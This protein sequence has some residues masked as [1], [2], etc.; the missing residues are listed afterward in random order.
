MGINT[1]LVTA[2]NQRELLKAEIEARRAS[3]ID[4]SGHESSKVFA[5]K[6]PQIDMSMAEWVK[7]RNVELA[8][9]QEEVDGY[10]SLDEELDK[11]DGMVKQGNKINRPP[12]SMGKR[13]RGAVAKFLDSDE[14]AKFAGSPSAE[15]QF[16]TE[17]SFKELFA[18]QR[19]TLFETFDAAVDGAV[20]VDVARTGEYVTVPRTEVTLLDVIPQL[21]TTQGQI[22]YDEQTLNESAVGVIAQGG[23]YRESAFKIEKKTVPVVTIGGFSQ[24]S[25]ELL[26]DKPEMENLLRGDLMDQMMRNAQD[27]FIG[28]TAFQNLTEYVGSPTPS[29]DITGF[30]DLPDADI[31]TFTGT[32]INEIAAIAQ[33]KEM[34]YRVG[35]A[36]ADAIVMNSQDWLD[37]ETLQSTTGAYLVGGSSAGLSQAVPMSLG[38]LPIILCNALPNHTVLVGAFGQHCTV[39]DRQ[40]FQVQVQ[41]AQY[42]PGL[43][44][45]GSDTSSATA[46]TTATHTHPSTMYNVYADARLAF[47]IRRGKAFTKITAFGE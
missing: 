3:S 43:T 29:G 20:S 24:V 37:V 47:Y 27:E 39:R 8:A 28:G 14:W 19:K 11:F 21:P 5:I 25:M 1:N 15:M 40:S 34:I 13:G 35:R 17:V 12:N 22:E 10:M 7:A 36:R 9:L 4:D 2:S 45:G 46:T 38:G 23:H 42:V 33:A 41:R 6:N 32:G 44:Y 31:N 16:N 18:E 30:L 26:Q